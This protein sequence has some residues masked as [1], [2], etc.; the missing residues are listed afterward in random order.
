ML[1]TPALKHNSNSNDDYSV[2]C[3]WKKIVFTLIL[4]HPNLS[5]NTLNIT[6]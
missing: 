2:D 4:K 3:Y 5:S 6:L 1:I